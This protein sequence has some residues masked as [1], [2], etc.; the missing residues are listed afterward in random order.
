MEWTPGTIYRKFLVLRV[1]E[2]N[3]SCLRAVISLVRCN[4]L[5]YYFKVKIFFYFGG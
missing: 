2:D 3:I 1:I 5:Q 4:G